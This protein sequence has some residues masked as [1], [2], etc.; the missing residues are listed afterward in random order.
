MT[1]F[2]KTDLQAMYARLG[3]HDLKLASGFGT[4]KGLVNIFDESLVQDGS[5]DLQ[6]TTTTIQLETDALVGLQ[7]GS[8]L[9]DQ[10]DAIHYRVQRFGQIGD[11]AE[12]MV[13]AAKLF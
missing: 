1:F 7:V 9:I 13:H 5:S 6:A 8:E 4:T 3:G 11:G 10:T 12:T 2:R